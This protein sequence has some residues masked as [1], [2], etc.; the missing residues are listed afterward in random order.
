[1]RGRIFAALLA[2]GGCSV[3][4]KQ[5]LD[6][7]GGIDAP[8]G[9]TGGPPNTTITAAPDEFSRFG[10]A[11]FEFT[12]DVVEVTFQCSIDGDT[13]VACTSPYTR[14]LG[15]GTHSFSVRAADARGADDDTPAEHVWT[16]DT[17]AP[18]TTLTSV[19]PAADNSVIV[20]FEFESRED[21]VTFDCALDG[22]GYAACESGVEVGPIGDGPHSFAVRARDRAGNLDAS[23]AIHA[24]SIDTSTPDTQ[25]ISG[26]SGATSNTSA[27]FSFVSPDAGPGATFQCAIDGGMFAACSSPHMISGLGEGEYTFAVRVRDAV[28][29]LDPTPAVRVWS[30]DLTPPDTVIATGPTGTVNVASASFMFTA[31]EPGVTYACSLDDAPFAAC[32]SPFSAPALAQG[33]HVFAVRATD[34]AGHVDP[35]P[36]TRAWTVDTIAPDLIISEGPADA[37][38]SGPRVTFTFTASEGQPACSLDGAAFSACT[39]PR[40]FNVPAGPHDFAIRAS[41]AAGNVATVMRAW[42]VAC[43]APDPLGAAGLLHLDDAD[44]VLVNAVPGGASASLGTDATVEL[45][46]PS[47]TT[48]RFGGAL[49]FA[50]L[51]NDRVAW[52]AAFGAMTELTIELWASPAAQAGSRELLI[53]GDGRVALRATAASPSTMTFSISIVPNGGGPPRVTTSAAVAAGQWHHVIASLQPPA[54]RLWVDGERTEITGVDVTM[55]P[56]L[57]ALRLGGE[58]E[59]AFGGLIDEV[60][61]AQT[62]IGADEAALARYCPL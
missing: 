28:G 41:D 33:P 40:S 19:P 54:L 15:D 49:S 47:F 36:A 43:A 55:P 5:P 38:T 18:G 51:E 24:W 35:A 56:A 23:P 22:G 46:D 48:G 4:E 39:S 13:P 30:V 6:R 3:S 10:A 9:P 27:S 50:A 29:N 7:D 11:T 32:T 12:A 31:T 20:S 25:L 34:P 53:S 44:Q 57:D 52:P 45:A 1:M 60:W 26:P 14:T 42:T 2:T 62:A 58:G 59:R 21:N 17:I 8:G 37:S 16:I 61:V